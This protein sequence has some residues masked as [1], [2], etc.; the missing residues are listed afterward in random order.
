MNTVLIQFKNDIIDE[1]LKFLLLTVLVTLLSFTAI[2]GTF[3]MDEIMSLFG[4]EN[5]PSLFEPSAAL[6]FQ[7][8]FGDQV[9]FGLLIMTL[10]SMGVLA[11][12][13]E[14]GAISFSLSR[15]I[16]RKSYTASRIIARI[17]A[18]TLPFILGSI[19]GWV[20][21]NLMFDPMP[22]VTLFGAML[23]IVLLFLY[24]GF[25]TTF[26]SSQMTGLN[27]GLTTITVLILQLTISIFQP[28]EFLS[29]FALSNFWA[30]ILIDI[31]FKWTFEILGKFFGLCLWVV[32][33]F[34]ATLISM[35]HRDL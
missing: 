18:L 15:P 7:D 24:M 3:Y 13:I 17:L 11:S 28:I 5:F 9:L 6:A 12:E 27:A 8:F 4:I 2:I 22:L 26:F 32:L 21:V 19:V 1:K 35:D 20:Y 16:S 34:I 25:L 33:P 23:P 14:S 30:E 10:G 29:P 31:N